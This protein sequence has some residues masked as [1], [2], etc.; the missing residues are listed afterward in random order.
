MKV[1]VIGGGMS[2][3]VAAYEAAR[4]G[5]K[6]VV[7]EKED[8]LGGHAKTVSV[9]GV[10]LDLGFMVF[11]RKVTVPFWMCIRLISI[12]FFFFRGIYIPHHFSLILNTSWADFASIL[13]VCHISENFSKDRSAIRQTL[14]VFMRH[15]LLSDSFLTIYFHFNASVVVRRNI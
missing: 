9:N 6:V 12:F 14:T 4:G 10:D 13:S 2:G 8:Y 1:G 11:N 7:Y 5:A 3:L 15:M